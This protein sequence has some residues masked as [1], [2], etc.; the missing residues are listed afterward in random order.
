[1]DAHFTESDLWVQ[2]FIRRLNQLQPGVD[3]S[4]A[5]SICLEVFTEASSLDPSEAADTYVAEREAEERRA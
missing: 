3:L 1:M 5:I 2:A 4:T